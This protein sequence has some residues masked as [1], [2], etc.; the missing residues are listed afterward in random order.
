MTDASPEGAVSD[1]SARWER[2]A[3]LFAD[4]RSGNVRAMDD[5]VRLMTPVLWHV[6]R[7][8]GLERTLTE[9]VVQSTWLALV[10][11]HEKIADGR[12]VSGWLTITAR[13]E[14]WRVSKSHRRA[15]A[16]ADEILE[17]MLPPTESTETEVA[18]SDE[19]RRLWT[20]VATLEDRCRRL[21][22]VVAFDDRPDYARIA[23]DLDMP[24]GSIGPTRKR[25]LTKLRTALVNTGFSDEGGRD[26]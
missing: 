12:A 22:R 5:L 19:A 24:I 14:A 11:G 8:Y 18:A 2:A 26:G 9:D 21:L 7:A 6:V 1:G 4:W 16:T 15:D 25:C 3:D 20:A 17:P 10:R 23:T 13:R